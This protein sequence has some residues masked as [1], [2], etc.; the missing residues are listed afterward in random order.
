MLCHLIQPKWGQPNC[1]S[2]SNKWFLYDRYNTHIKPLDNIFKAGKNVNTI[3]ASST[4]DDREFSINIYPFLIL[5]KS[6]LLSEASYLMTIHLGG[7][8]LE[9]FD[10]FPLC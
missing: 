4:E 5:G 3:A 8:E 1:I 10:A 7:K 6:F 2:H 9:E